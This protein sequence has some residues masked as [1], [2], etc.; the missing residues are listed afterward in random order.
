MQP[1]SPQSPPRTLPRVSRALTFLVLA[2]FWATLALAQPFQVDDVYTQTDAGFAVQNLIDE[3]GGYVYY[4]SEEEDQGVSL[5]RTDGSAAGTEMVHDLW[6]GAGSPFRPDDTIGGMAHDGELYFGTIDSAAGLELWKSD[7]TPGGTS[8][9]FDTYPGADFRDDPKTRIMGS[10]GSQLFFIGS[11]PVN[12]DALWVTDGTPGGTMLVEDLTPGPTFSGNIRNPRPGVELDGKLIFTAR[13]G[14]GTAL[15]VSDGTAAGTEALANPVF[16]DIVDTE[17]DDI[18]RLG[19]YV[20]FSAEDPTHGL[21]LWRTDGT[22]GGTQL[23]ADIV[24]GDASSRP[25]YLRSDGTHLYFQ[26]DGEAWRTDGTPSGTQLFADINGASDSDPRYFRTLPGGQ[27][28]FFATTNA[29]GEELW[30][31][32]G[33]PGGT[34]LVRELMPG[35]PDIT[36]EAPRI[37]DDQ[38]FFLAEKDDNFLLKPFVSDGSAAGTFEL[39]PA[40]DGRPPIHRAF[41]PIL[42]LGG[43]AV[44]VTG[45]ARNAYQVWTSNGT[46]AGTQAIF[47]P[48]TNAGSNPQDP[49]IGGENIFWRATGD[50]TNLGLFAAQGAG[51]GAVVLAGGQG[52]QADVRQPRFP[53][54]AGSLVYF[55]ATTESGD[56]DEIYVTDGTRAGTTRFSDFPGVTEIFQVGHANGLVFASIFDPVTRKQPWVTD[57]TPG[58]TFQL[59]NIGSSQSDV[60]DFTQVG[61]TDR[62]LFTGEN[63]RQSRTYTTD[64]TVAGTE[65]LFA[66]PSIDDP[67]QYTRALGKVFFVVSEGRQYTVYV[68]DGTPGGTMNLQ[69]GIPTTESPFPEQL[70]PAPGMNLVFFTGDSD[71]FGRELWRTDGTV[72][73]TFRI[74]DLHVGAEDSQVKILGEYLGEMWFVAYDGT[75]TQLYSTTGTT[76]GITA[77]AALERLA[78][79]GVL[80]S[81][82]VLDGELYFSCWNLD[83]GLELWST[84]GTAVG[85]GPVSDIHAGAFASN[86]RELLLAGDFLAFTASDGGN[87]EMWMLPASDWIFG[88]GLETLD[89]SRWGAVL[90]FGAEVLANA[91]AA[92]LGEGG[93]EVVVDA[94]NDKGSV[95]DLSPDD[96]RTYRMSFFFDPNGMVFPE[97]K[98]LKILSTRMADN[99]RHI[100]ATLRWRA[101]TGYQLRV[102]THHENLSDWF[103]TFWYEVDPDGSQVTIEWQ[104]ASAPGVA[105]GVLK[106]RIDG[107]LVETVTG[108]INGDL[109]GTDWVQL[110]VVGGVT[111]GISGSHYF[112]DFRSW[113]SLLP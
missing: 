50:S 28:V 66:S 99:K 5:W 17:E 1:V 64:G 81:G 63:N 41:G 94:D 112:D 78:H 24:P 98:R 105:D 58:G 93:L 106:L 79:D 72:A 60:R 43:E 75:T 47:D 49:V 44:F 23:F 82:R 8:I 69:P 54:A 108:I 68:S 100:E 30:T 84:D 7:G 83:G 57:G 10:I 107:V 34:T 89:T 13:I 35:N 9:F 67:D 80:G 103:G 21:E 4:Y 90:E 61:A 53:T 113:S 31:S 102:K 15:I 70:T 62:V 51:G 95:A 3:V 6:P 36:I 46:S 45:E 92:S 76:A 59:I 2:A 29:L 87:R 74:T 96:E 20:Y 110:G 109:P 14:I 40:N 27:V 38:I 12:Q 11:D 73:G 101:A 52:Q 86:P 56:G 77:V 42:E 91:G 48:V 25:L 37:I 104:Q 16:I 71:A 33:T 18:A 85:T 65:L 39:D 88:D 19:N 97:N 55:S 32:D 26:A 111:P 22:P